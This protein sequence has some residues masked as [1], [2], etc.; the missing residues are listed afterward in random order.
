[1][2]EQP[3]NKKIILS[4]DEQKEIVRLFRSSVRGMKLS[5]RLLDPSG[6]GFVLDGLSKYGYLCLVP[7]AER[8]YVLYPE[9][10]SG[11][12]WVASD[13][14]HT[15]SFLE[16]CVEAKAA[17]YRRDTKGFYWCVCDSGAYRACCEKY[18]ISETDFQELPRLDPNVG[19]EPEV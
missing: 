12:A 5:K 16:D 4:E 6:I 11:D 14:F 7:W 1:M 2:S 8:V 19:I 10:Y 9:D 18:G 13:N 15:L 3:T 17:V